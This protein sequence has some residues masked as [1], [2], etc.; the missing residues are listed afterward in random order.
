MVLLSQ[1]SSMASADPDGAR[2]AFTK[3]LAENFTS[4]DELGLA[5]YES[6]GRIAVPLGTSYQQ[7]ANWAQ[8]YTVGDGNMAAGLRTAVDAMVPA[9]KSG[10]VWFVILLTDGSVTGPDPLLEA[11]RA[12]Q[13]GVRVYVLCLDGPSGGKCQTATVM[14]IARRTGGQLY[15]SLPSDLHQFVD[16]FAPEPEPPLKYDVAGKPPRSGD[17]MVTFPLTLNI[18]VVPGSFRCI[19]LTCTR[20]APDA[21]APDQIKE[22]NRGA[23]LTWTAPVRELRI[24]QVWEVE[25]SVRSHDSGA[26]V[27]VNLETKSI[28]SYDRYDG[29]PGGSDW[30]GRLALEVMA[31]DRECAV[32]SGSAPFMHESPRLAPAGKDLSLSVVPPAEDWFTICY[33]FGEIVSRYEGTVSAWAVMIR[34]SAP[35]SGSGV[36]SMEPPVRPD[37]EWTVVI[38]SRFLSPGLLEYRFEALMT[39]S[40]VRRDPERADAKPF[41]LT[42]YGDP[43]DAV[44]EIQLPWFDL[45]LFLAAGAALGAVAGLRYRTLGRTSPAPAASAMGVFPDRRRF[46]VRTANPATINA[47]KRA[48]QK[49]MKEG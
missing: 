43:E 48:A 27:P 17:P 12:A 37:G 22:G 32:A 28:V 26:R 7:V 20:P 49:R 34:F 4:V 16:Y 42:L 9:K 21:P 38:P 41:E 47:I 45:V 44:V 13:E 1:S 39:N 5:D 18:E 3:R 2:C 31:R 30:F 25:F 6:S 33:E 35:G 24:R 19:S 8:C 40:S 11:D 15:R 46:R 14:E 36:Y 10:F 23:A 29:S